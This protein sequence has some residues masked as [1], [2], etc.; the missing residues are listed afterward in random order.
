MV[1]TQEVVGSIPITSILLTT[2]TN[3]KGDVGELRVSSKLL[4]MG[5][6][7][8][9]TITDT[10]YD[11]IAEINDEFVSV[12]VKV[13]RW[14]EDDNTYRVGFEKTNYGANGANRD[15]YKEGEIDVF[16]IYNPDEDEIYWLWFDEAPK[17]GASRTLSSWR[18]DLID[19]KI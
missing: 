4:E 12:Q 7:V 18:N 2:N 3:R 13:C 8:S 11:L 5:Y 14:S 16:A 17:W 9:E 15:L 6:V 10:H 19:R 1:F